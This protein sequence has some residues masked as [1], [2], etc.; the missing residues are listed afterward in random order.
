MDEPTA[1][2]ARFLARALSAVILAGAALACAPQLAVAQNWP[3][4]PI[5]LIA[6][7]PAGGGFDTVA[8]VLADRMRPLLGQPIVVENR[9]GA[10]TRVGTQ[11]AAKAAPDGYT[12]M[13]GALSN[14][15]LN[16]GLYA[17][18]PYDPIKDFRLVGIAV[19]WSYTLVARKDLPQNSLTEVIAFA[20]ANPDKVTYA[21]AGN[22]S[23]QHVA[24]AATEKLSG[25]KLTHV[26]YRGAQDAYQDILG[27]RVDLFFDISSTAKTQVEGGS[28]KAL[29]VSSKERQPFHPDV[30]S[31]YETGAPLDMESWF[32]LF[33]PAGTPEPI[34]DKL[35][36]A[37][38]EVMASRDVQ[39]LF[40]KTGGVVSKLSSQQAQEKVR[41]DI[42]RWTR[43]LQE[44][45][46]KG[47]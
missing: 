45:G 46:L 12:L 30:P 42:E 38:A 22:G 19:T 35:R 1:S 13:I 28:V 44:I 27:G 5:T 14:M 10:G 18:L 33:A 15:A 39:E 43:L 26:P 11:A 32:G 25:V 40:A 37:M 6:P 9:T 21:S 16:P 47:E 29:A 36:A 23:G 24:M 3:T 8:R 2:G 34:L 17:N 41:S 4:R 7:N 31:V 20:K